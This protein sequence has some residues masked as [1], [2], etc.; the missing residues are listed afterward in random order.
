MLRE[1][2][3]E[4][5]ELAGLL[6]GSHDGAGDLQDANDAINMALLIRPRDGKAWIIKSYIMSCFGDDPAALAAAEMAL[7]HLPRSAE[8]HFVQASVLADME[9]FEEA[10]ARLDVAFGMM[11]DEDRRLAED[12]HYLKGFLLDA[13]GRDGD[14]EEA[15]EDGLRCCPES[16]LLRGRLEPLRRE[17]LRRVLTVIDGGRTP[18]E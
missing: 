15:Y 6:L 12:L 10:L 11:V 5:L 8:A 9:R 4:Y 3:E 18:A 7:R 1:T 16:L 17:R 14:A 2:F 13:L